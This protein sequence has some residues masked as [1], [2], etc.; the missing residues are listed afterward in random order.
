MGTAPLTARALYAWFSHAATEPVNRSH[1][2]W[3][4]V[5]TRL[6]ERAERNGVRVDTR[7]RKRVVISFRG[8]E[9]SVREQGPGD[10]GPLYLT[11][12]AARGACGS[13]QEFIKMV[14]A[15]AEEAIVSHAMLR[16][17]ING[18]D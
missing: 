2:E 6:I 3:E 1:D 9:V 14:H 17:A 13:D 7:D 10:R 12:L 5:R 4:S 15:L 18:S 8:G 11:L 16:R